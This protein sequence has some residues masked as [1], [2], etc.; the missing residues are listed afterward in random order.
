MIKSQ[1]LLLKK[2]PWHVT[3]GC[4]HSVRRRYLGQ[5]LCLAGGEGRWCYGEGSLASSHQEAPCRKRGAARAADFVDE[6]ANGCCHIFVFWYILAGYIIPI[7]F[8]WTHLETKTHPCWLIW[9]LKKL[10]AD[11]SKLQRSRRHHDRK[12]IWGMIH[13][14]PLRWGRWTSTYYLGV[15][16]PG[17]WPIYPQLIKHFDFRVGSGHSFLSST[18]LRC[19]KNRI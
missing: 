6:T 19:R 13:Q 10:A 17:F 2:P 4:L 9:G 7:S 16:V 1:R 5:V 12:W 11:L 15:R 3:N 8:D 18:T 14:H